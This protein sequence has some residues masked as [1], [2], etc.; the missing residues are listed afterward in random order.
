MEITR[1]GSKLEDQQFTV[2]LSGAQL[3]HI[4]YLGW[5]KEAGPSFP[6]AYSKKRITDQIEEA[7]GRTHPIVVQG[8]EIL[9]CNLY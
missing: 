3:L 8:K 4:Y 7:L 6:S 9:P 5:S 1:S 2:T